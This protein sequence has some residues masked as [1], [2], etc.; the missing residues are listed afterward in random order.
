VDATVPI[1]PGDYTRAYAYVTSRPTC[2]GELPVYIDY[3]THPAGDPVTRW[4]GDHEPV[5]R[6]V[7]LVQPPRLADERHFRLPPGLPPEHGE[8]LLA[9]LRSLRM[10]EP[11]L[12]AGG[13]EAAPGTSSASDSDVR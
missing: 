6:P 12:N 3:C 1:P 9:F 13:E 2:Q 11:K 5:R 7:R 4:E 10:G 8:Q